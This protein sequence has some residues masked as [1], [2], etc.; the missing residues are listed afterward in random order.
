LDAKQIQ[1]RIVQ[2]ILECDLDA[3]QDEAVR[4]RHPIAV[5]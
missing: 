1:A 3:E 5:F 4:D 2:A